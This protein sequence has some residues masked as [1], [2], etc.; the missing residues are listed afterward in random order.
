[1]IDPKNKVSIRVDGKKYEGWLEVSIQANIDQL[2]RQFAMRVTDNFPGNVAF[3][4]RLKA[5]QLVEVFIGTDLVCTGYIVSTP[6]RYDARNISVEV[7][8]KSRTIDL[9]ECCLPLEN[10]IFTYQAKNNDSW[11]QVRT[12]PKKDSK[13]VVCSKYVGHSWHNKKTAEIIADLAAVYGIETYCSFAG[14][15]AKVTYFN[16]NPTDTVFGSIQKLLKTDNLVVTDDEFGN[17]RIVEVGE[18][19][20]AHDRLVALSPDNKDQPISGPYT[21]ILS[22]SASFDASK[23]FQTYCFIGAHKGDDGQSGKMVCQD[24][25]DAT[26]NEISRKR[27]FV[28]KQSGQAS[29]QTCQERAAFENNFRKG[30]FNK[31]TYYVQGWRQSDGKLWTPN[32]TVDVDDY[33]LD[34]IDTLLIESTNFIL[35]DQGSITELTVLPPNG[36][37]RKDNKE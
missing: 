35:N 37:R 19:G 20:R 1:M 22:A 13:P 34:R 16:V 11:A 30:Q 24:R 3:A 27:I 25:G 14:E 36:Y 15:T 9:V 31:V 32:M 12:S 2:C 23:R 8:G 6:I 21:R 26:D 29:N 7:H 33:I 28:G 17:V 18:A 10:E 4:K 5:G